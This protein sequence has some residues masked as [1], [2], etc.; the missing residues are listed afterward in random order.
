MAL[1]HFFEAM[2]TFISHDA[3]VTAVSWNLSCCEIKKKTEEKHLPL[4]LREA[5]R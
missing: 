4:K 3:Q 5:A 2:K 1:E